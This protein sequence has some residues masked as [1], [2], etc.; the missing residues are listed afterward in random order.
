MHRLPLLPYRYDYGSF[1]SY[2]DH[3]SSP[4][5]K[6][7]HAAGKAGI[8]KKGHGEDGIEQNQLVA[9]FSADNMALALCSVS[10]HSRSATES[11]TM[12]A[13]D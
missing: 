10:S 6:L 2:F 12:P 3:L 1:L 5:S 11:M 8:Q 7:E 13:P 4:A 9:F